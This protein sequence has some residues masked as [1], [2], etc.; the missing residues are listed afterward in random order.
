VLDYLRVQID[1]SSPGSPVWRQSVGQ[2]IEELPGHARGEYGAKLAPRQSDDER[3][4]AT[5]RFKDLTRRFHAAA[6][7]SH[8]REQARMEI[9][10]KIVPRPDSCLACHGEQPPRLDFEAAG[11]SPAR[12][13]ALRAAPT[14]RMMQSIR[15]GQPFHLPGFIQP[16]ASQP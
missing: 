15:Q 8:D 12:S 6:P 3:Q 16:P 1:T 11:Y 14:A 9:H 4:R 13:A 2:L 10:R 5:K 7:G